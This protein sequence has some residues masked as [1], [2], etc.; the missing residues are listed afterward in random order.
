VLKKRLIFTLLWRRGQYCLSRNYTLQ[1][2]GDLAWINRHYNFQVI[3]FSIDELVVL[4]V[5]RREKELPRFAQDLRE[6]CRGSFMPLA[7]GG[8]V[9]SVADAELLLRSGADKVV[10]NTLVHDAPEVVSE[11]ARHFGDQCVV[12][13]IDYKRTTNGLE[14]FTHDGSRATGL[15][16]MTVVNRV[17]RL[18]AGELYVTSMDRDGTGQGYD[19]DTLD[20]VASIARTP[21]IASGGVGKFEHLGEWL[22]RPHGRAAS[23]A[24][25]FNFLGGGLVEA[26]THLAD[27]GVPMATWDFGWR[28]RA[29]R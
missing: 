4:N 28:E 1:S 5:A 21:V 24:N 25:I 17:Q 19:L 8:G 15:D 7:A 22:V 6:L 18:G 11:I 2:A 12:A 16:L 27:A 10:V 23:T 9:R 26:R 29:A 14:V 20:A 13:S 3:S